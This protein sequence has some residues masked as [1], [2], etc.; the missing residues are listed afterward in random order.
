MTEP[1]NLERLHI[2]GDGESVVGAAYRGTFADGPTRNGVA[3]ASATLSGVSGMGATV[4]YCA[5][6]RDNGLK[7]HE[8]ADKQAGKPT[9]AMQ[10]KTQGA[11][12]HQD[13]SSNIREGVGRWRIAAVSWVS[14]SRQK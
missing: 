9:L 12:P 10:S 5:N 8:W 7:P 3:D 14:M 2:Y 11:K 4:V 13:K 1:S 6:P